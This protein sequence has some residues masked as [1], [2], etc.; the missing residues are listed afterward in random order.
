MRRSI[1]PY[2][3]FHSQARADDEASHKKAMDAAIEAHAAELAARLSTTRKSHQALHPIIPCCIGHRRHLLTPLLGTAS[4]QAEVASLQRELSDLRGQ[5]EA[6]QSMH[7]A[8]VATLETEL[9]TLRRAATVEV[10]AAAREK[11]ALQADLAAAQEAHRKE[12]AAS[13][14][15]RALNSGVPSFADRLSSCRSCSGG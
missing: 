8:H 3:A 13:T 7:A 5:Q 2:V 10:E 14:V 1:D 6:M 15:R 9:A 11:A 4:L 12:L